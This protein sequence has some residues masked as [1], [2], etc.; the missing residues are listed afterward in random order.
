[1]HVHTEVVNAHGHGVKVFSRSG[2]KLR[3]ESEIKVLAVLENALVGVVHACVGAHKLQGLFE[4][5]EDRVGRF[6]VVGVKTWGWIKVQTKLHFHIRE[7]VLAK[8]HAQQVVPARPFF[9]TRR[10]VRV[11]V[12]HLVV[13]QVA[14]LWG[15]VAN[16]TLQ[17][18]QRSADAV[19]SVCAHVHVV[20]G[21]A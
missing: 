1:M 7:R 9:C 3:P 5:P 2:H 19:A 14:R 8:V 20:V 18:T 16:V 11:A 15:H 6:K 13:A 12:V 17:H 21:Q 10:N 4:R